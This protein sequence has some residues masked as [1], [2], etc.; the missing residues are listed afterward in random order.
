M[1]EGAVLLGLEGGRADEADEMIVADVD[2][3]RG[4]KSNGCRI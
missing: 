1:A 2:G 4:L 3:R